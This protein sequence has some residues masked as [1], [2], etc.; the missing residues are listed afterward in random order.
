MLDITLRVATNIMLALVLAVVVALGF[1]IGFFLPS[2]AHAQEP[3]NQP[4]PVPLTRPEMKK[5]LEDLKSR[6]P[7]IP[8]PEWTQAEKEKL[9]EKG[10]GYEARLRF[11]YMPGS[12]GKGGLGFVREPDPKMSLSY[13]FKTQLF[14][15]VSRANNCHY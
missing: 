5:A 1:V 13:E 7:R 15:I 2:C 10:T 14:W 9:G 11:L 4:L 8:L 12:D 3:A 6:T